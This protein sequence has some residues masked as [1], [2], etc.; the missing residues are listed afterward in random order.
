MPSSKK[1]S[2]VYSVKMVENVDGN[3]FNPDF[4]FF[5]PFFANFQKTLFTLRWKPGFSLGRKLLALPLLA[6]FILMSAKVLQLAESK[7]QENLEYVLN[8]RRKKG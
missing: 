2:V 7:R 5:S 8:T 1:V 3:A 4:F 6:V